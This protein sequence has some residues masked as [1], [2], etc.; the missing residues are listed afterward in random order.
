LVLGV[1]AGVSGRTLFD[2]IRSSAVGSPLFEHCARQVLDRKFKN[3]GSRIATMYK[4]L[5]ISMSVARE[6][7]AAM[8]ATSAAY[9]IFQAGISRFPDEDNWAVAKWLEEI[10]DT[11]VNW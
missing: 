10:A 11:E 5:G 8:F 6:S 3:T 9:E 4:D 1:K 7:G 2:V